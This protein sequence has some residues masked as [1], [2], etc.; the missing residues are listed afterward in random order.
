MT[1]V[2]TTIAERV[3][4]TVPQTQFSASPEPV[5]KPY[6]STLIKVF[7]VGGGGCNAVE[8]MFRQQVKGVE[9]YAINTDIQHLARCQVANR[10]PIGQKSTRGLGVGGEPEKGR[11]AAE[12]SKAELARL[13]DGADMVFVAA[14]MGGG[15]GT[16]AAPVLA[17][18]ARDLGVL[19]VAVVTQPFS[20][21]GFKRRKNA[22]EGIEN[23]RKAADTVITISNDRLLQL[24]AN[25]REPYTWEE[26]MKLADSV[27]S[28]GVQAIAEVVTVPG[29]INVDFA[30]VK[31]IMTGAGPTWM[32]VG[33][34]KGE[35]RATDA[36]R[37]ATRSP[38]LDIAIDGAK[39]ILLVI[40]GGS[41][42]TIKEVEE[43]ASAVYEMADPDANIIFGT[44]R[45]DT[46]GDEVK[47]TLIAAS[48]PM[49]RESLVTGNQ[50]NLKQPAAPATDN[51]AE[52]KLDVYRVSAFKQMEASTGRRQRSGFFNSLRRRLPVASRG[53]Q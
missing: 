31:A 33:R 16:G 19:T 8:R 53:P 26:A 21:E 2:K 46:L 36:V 52:P 47:I 37:E 24:D 40:S 45:D 12:E 25:R 39:R 17:Q 18:V 20:F 32:A 1:P 23:L 30:D 14:G 4:G 50:L 42:L 51:P 29:E 7:G 34:G 27:L 5:I 3:Q 10:I 28:Q 43:A 13:V 15:T 6:G 41:D 11:M 48:F 49:A 22:Q 35:F 38:L 44:V 9:Y